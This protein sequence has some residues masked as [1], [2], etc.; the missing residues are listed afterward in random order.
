MK[1]LAL[2]ISLLLIIACSTSPPVNKKST[3]T[4]QNT[5]FQR[6]TKFPPIEIQKQIVAQVEKNQGPDHPALSKPL[7]NIAFDYFEKGDYSKAETIFERVLHIDEKH[8]SNDFFTLALDKANLAAAK[9]YGQK[10][11]EAEVLAQDA[12]KDFYKAIGQGNNA[13]ILQE[14]AGFFNSMCNCYKKFGKD[15]EARKYEKGRDE[16]LQKLKIK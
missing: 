3:Q 8:R 4:N 16:I 1:S 10:F 13:R 14:N 12:G 7:T 5:A 9:C 11:A 15:A 2:L 6:D